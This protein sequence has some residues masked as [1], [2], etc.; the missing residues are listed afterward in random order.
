MPEQGLLC[1]IFVDLCFQ[2]KSAVLCHVPTPSVKYH[3]YCNLWQSWLGSC[4]MDTFF[5]SNIILTINISQQGK[6]SI[7]NA[8]ILLKPQKNCFSKFWAYPMTVTNAVEMPCN[9]NNALSQKQNDDLI[10]SVS[11]KIPSCQMFDLTVVVMKV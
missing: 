3:I 6:V 9:N 11:P 2:L 5:T 10:D 7:K 1:E 8:F 4:L